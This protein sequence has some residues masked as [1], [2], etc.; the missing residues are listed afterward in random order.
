MRFLAD[1]NIPGGLVRELRALGH[2]V[3]YAVE[4]TPDEE[5]ANLLIRAMQED[6]VLITLDTDFGDLVYMNGMPAACGE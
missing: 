2:S 1:A 6:R 5:D 4:E 3:V